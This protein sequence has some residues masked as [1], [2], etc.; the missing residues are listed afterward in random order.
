MWRLALLLLTTTALA[1]PVAVATGADGSSVT[2]R[3]DAGPCVGKA[4]SASWQSADKRT[5]V[6]GCWVMYPDGSVHISYL[7]GDR[8]IIRASSFVKARNL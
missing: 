6:P 3:S 2:L 4:L 8:G 5:S 1:Q 7:D